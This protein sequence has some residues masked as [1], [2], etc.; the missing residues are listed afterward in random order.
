[1]KISDLPELTAPSA[2]AQTVIVDGSTTYRT[3]FKREA[4]DIGLTPQLT[5][6]SIE[7]SQGVW[8]ALKI[9]KVNW[10]TPSTGA[11]IISQLH[12]IPNV[13]RFFDFRLMVFDQSINESLSITTTYDAGEP[14]RFFAN[15]TTMFVGG[16]NKIPNAYYQNA[17]A[18]FQ[19]WEL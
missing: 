12:G 4:V 9:I 15:R 2:S 14:L 18:V 3:G 1:M 16:A 11:N 17:F 10:N 8:K 19:Y 7:I 5:G 6:Q 13:D